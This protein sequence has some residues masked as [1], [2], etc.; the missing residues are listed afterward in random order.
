MPN[1]GPRVRERQTV[2]NIYRSDESVPI[3]TKTGV[4]EYMFDVTS[5]S[6]LLPRP[7]NSCYHARLRDSSPAVLGHIYVPGVT[8]TYTSGAYSSL[9][10]YALSAAQ[11]VL[12]P[13]LPRLKFNLTTLEFQKNNNFNLL[14]FLFEWAETLASLLNPLSLASYGGYKWGIKPIISDV[15]SL[16]DTF[17]DI[18]GRISENLSRKRIVVNSSAIG[19][20]DFGRGNTFNVD[21][22]VRGSGFMQPGSLDLDYFDLIRIFLDEIGLHFNLATLWDALPLSFLL[23]GYVPIGASLEALH[24]SRWFRPV[25]KFDG[26]YTAKGTVV[27]E[28]IPHPNGAQ[29]FYPISGTGTFDIF[30]RA[31]LSFDSSQVENN[32]SW[33]DEPPLFDTAYI[34]Y[35]AQRNNVNK[36]IAKYRK[37]LSRKPVR[38]SSAK[39]LRKLGL[40]KLPF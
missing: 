3:G 24:P 1:Y 38:G 13:S 12:E 40:P 5:S 33:P 11:R 10:T 7:Y 39:L 30:V 32:I 37:S 16:I 35:G 29:G 25:I 34:A 18:F 17:R 15:L 36:G 4:S 14:I 23:D 28:G 26:G 9:T 27:A 6:K 19:S 2:Y 20:I 31:P 21:L 22:T 8:W